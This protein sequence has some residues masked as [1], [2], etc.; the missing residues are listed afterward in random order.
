VGLPRAQRRRQVDAVKVLLGA[1]CARLRHGRECWR[2]T[3]RQDP[4]EVRRA[5]GYMP[6]WTRTCP[7]SR[8]RNRSSSRLCAACRAASRSAARTRSSSY[9]GLGEA[10]TARSSSTRRACGRGCASHRRSSTTAARLP[11]RADDGLDPKGRDEV[12]AVITDLS[13]AHARASSSARTSSRRRG[14]VQHVVV[15]RD[16]RVATQGDVSEIRQARSPARTASASTATAPV[17]R[18]A[19][20]AGAEARAT[21]TRCSSSACPTSGP[22][23]PLRV[24]AASACVVRELVRPGAVARG[25][26]MRAMKRRRGGCLMRSSSRATAATWREVGKSRAFAI[27]WEN[28]RRASGRGTWALLFALTFWP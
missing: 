17:R 25:A 3:C 27:A 8:A 6:R 11:R 18:G 24:A 10:R 14:G 21:K 15:M 28:V 13:T 4:M 1:S 12:A 19:A 9:V 16:G 26:F 7:G 23:L 22:R 20:A 5:V 2:G